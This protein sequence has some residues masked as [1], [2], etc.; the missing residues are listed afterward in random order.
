MQLIG[1]KASLDPRSSPDS[2][3]SALCDRTPAVLSK[4]SPPPSWRYNATLIIYRLHICKFPYLLKCICKP[5]IN[6]HRLS[7]SF[8]QPLHSGWIC[9]P[10]HKTSLHRTSCHLKHI[11]ANCV[12]KPCSEI[13]RDPSLVR[14]RN[15]LP[16]SGQKLVS[17]AWCSFFG[18]KSVIKWDF[19]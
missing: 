9:V 14:S 17:P 13:H 19:P 16:S 3:S 18:W 5:Q 1:D 11:Q 10:M 4:V 8:P 15:S 12:R 7:W 6:T 2:V